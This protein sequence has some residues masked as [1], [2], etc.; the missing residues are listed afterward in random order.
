MIN[1]KHLS[2][3]RPLSLSAAAAYIGR[4]TGDKPHISTIWR[5]CSKGC[6]GIRLESIYIGGKRY[7]TVSAIERFIEALS[8]PD[9]SSA[10][11][12]GITPASPAVSGH[13]A[14]RRAEIEAA[15]QRLDLLTRRGSPRGTAGDASSPNR[16][17]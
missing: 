8:Q 7:V 1:V 9:D 10:T 16:S 15:R 2:E 5:W 14:R 17:A 11:A 13:D 12:R 3:E 4:L 6:K